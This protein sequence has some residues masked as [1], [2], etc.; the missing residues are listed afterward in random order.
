VSYPFLERPT[1]PPELQDLYDYRKPL[2]AYGGADA[3]AAQFADLVQ[4][5]AGHLPSLAAH[6]IKGQP[7]EEQRYRLAVLEQQSGLIG[8]DAVA[9]DLFR[10]LIA[11][12]SERAGIAPRPGFVPSEQVT[13]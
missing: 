7:I 6:W 2:F 5:C 8:W 12:Q 10:H 11:M 3:Y 9:A 4:D 1:L 13:P